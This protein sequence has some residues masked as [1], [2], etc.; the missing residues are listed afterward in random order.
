MSHT[1]AAAIRAE[2]ELL[3]AGW[4]YVTSIRTTETLRECGF[5]LR[6]VQVHALQGAWFT[7][8]WVMRLYVA[9][10]GRGRSFI[11]VE[12][13]LRRGLTPEACEAAFA[14]G[15]VEA[16]VELAQGFGV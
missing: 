10:T 4:T 14:L 9:S 3:A 6:Y 12:G 5:P 8:P 11:A 13:A 7:R 16:I 15:G 2:R 1:E